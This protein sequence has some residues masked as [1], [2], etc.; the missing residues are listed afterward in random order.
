MPG[1][2]GRMKVDTIAQTMAGLVQC[3]FFSEEKRAYVFCE[4]LTVGDH[5]PEDTLAHCKDTLLLAWERARSAI[6]G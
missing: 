3:G 2:P 6:V 4:V 1:Q 5:S